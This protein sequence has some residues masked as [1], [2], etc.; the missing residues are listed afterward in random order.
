M[1]G[2]KLLRIYLND[3]RA[4]STGAVELAKRCLSSNQGT[5][6]APFL[7]DLLREIESDRS[8][9]E[10]V[11]TALAMPKDRF[12]GAAAW[13]A[14]KAGRLKSNGRIRGYSDLS[15]VLELETLYLMVEGKVLLWR[16]LRSIAE[17]DARLAS[18]DFETLAERGR[19]QMAQLDEHRRDAVATAFPSARPDGEPRTA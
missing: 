6:L 14:E 19:T 11:M 7:Q 18:F 4:V 9:L 1:T 12:K 17:A 16:N 2:N 10:A 13:M 15:R 3:H 8:T 5:S